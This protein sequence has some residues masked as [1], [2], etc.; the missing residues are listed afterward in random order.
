MALGALIIKERLGV[1]DDE[2]VEPVGENP[3]LQYFV[4]VSEYSD[5]APSDASM[6]THFRQRLSLELVSQVNEAVVQAVLV[7]EACATGA[8]EAEAA[9]PADTATA[10]PPDETH[11]ASGEP[12]EDTLPHRGQPL[13]DAT[14]APADIHYPTDLHLLNPASASS[15]RILDQFWAL[16]R[17]PGQR[18]PR[19]YRQ[20]ARRNRSTQI[21]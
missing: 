7:P 17:Q 2:T 21:P 5:R 12:P 15:E 19:T 16:V 10:A 14:V 6:M 1:S 13:L 9:S 11:E 4:G 18:K 20:Q 3:Y 8:P